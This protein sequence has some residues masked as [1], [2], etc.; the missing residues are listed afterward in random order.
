[1]PKMRLRKGLYNEIEAA[2][3][4]GPF[5]AQPPTWYSALGMG[6]FCLPKILKQT[7]DNKQPYYQALMACDAGHAGNNP[8]F[9]EPLIQLISF[10]PKEQLKQALS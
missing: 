1:M 10:L 6:I 8:I 2:S 5:L 4:G 9:P 7:V 3:I